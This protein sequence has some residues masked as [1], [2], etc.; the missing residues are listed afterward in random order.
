MKTV[1]MRQLPLSC[2]LGFFSRKSVSLLSSAV[3]PKLRGHRAAV[4]SARMTRGEMWLE[5]KLNGY[6][7]CGE[8]QT[9]ADSIMLT[10]I[11]VR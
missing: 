5:S 8:K 3:V 10:Y 11:S 9:D 7:L 1:I 6:D 4:R 2:G